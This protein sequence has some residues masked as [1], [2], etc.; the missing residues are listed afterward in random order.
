A[1][2]VPVDAPPDAQTCFGNGLLSLCL[3]AP[4]M[5]QLTITA[6]MTIDTDTSPLCVPYS[7]DSGESA[8]CVVAA[9]TVSVESDVR[10]RAIGTK[11]LVVIATGDIAVDGTIDVAS[12]AGANPATCLAPTAATGRRG[13]AGGSWYGRGG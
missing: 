4:P 8:L 9:T 1:A 3:T 6:D 5:M 12:G 13:G 11:P 7:G 2:I 10:L